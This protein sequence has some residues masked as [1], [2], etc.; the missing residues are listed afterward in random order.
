MSLWV[1]FPAANAVIA[2][3]CAQY[4]LYPLFPSCTAPESATRLIAAVVIGEHQSQHS[5][6]LNQ[7]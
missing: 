3:T 5:M 6:G 7:S 1:I 4:L 2:L